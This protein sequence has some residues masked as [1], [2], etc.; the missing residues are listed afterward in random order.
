MRNYK[1]FCL[2]NDTV[3]LNGFLKNHPQDTTLFADATRIPLK[4]SSVDV[5]FCS[6]LSHHIPE[7]VLIKLLAEGKRVLN[8]AGKFIFLDAIYRQ[9]SFLNRFLWSLDRGEYPHTEEI[10]LSSL[11]QH[12]NIDTFEKFSRYY[13]YIFIV[14]S[15]KL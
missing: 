3:K 13:D 5:V 12:F 10:L 11:K 4:N 14:G 7:E 1:Y 15:K 9:E 8:P 2:D 6:S